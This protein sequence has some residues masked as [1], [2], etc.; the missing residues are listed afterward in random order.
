MLCK[1]VSSSKCSL[2]WSVKRSNRLA[3]Q[4]LQLASRQCINLSMGLFGRRRSR[5]PAESTSKSSNQ[6]ANPVSYSGNEQP[7]TVSADLEPSRLESRKAVSQ[8]WV[9]I[10]SRLAEVTKSCSQ[11]KR[12]SQRL[13]DFKETLERLSSA[14]GIHL[15]LAGTSVAERYDPVERRLQTIEEGL[16][17][18]QAAPLGSPQSRPEATADEIEA[19][20]MNSSRILNLWLERSQ[21]DI[22]EIHR[23]EM[24]L[25]NLNLLDTIHGTIGRILD[26]VRHSEAI[27]GSKV[28]LPREFPPGSDHESLDIDVI[29]NRM[30]RRKQST[31]PAFLGS[32][33]DYR[34]VPK[35]RRCIEVKGP[36]SSIR[37][38]CFEVWMDTLCPYSWRNRLR[39]LH[40][41]FGSNHTS[42]VAIW[43]RSRL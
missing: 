14:L 1:V 11:S 23:D 10:E 18:W 35:S 37:T 12:S 32:A 13:E 20:R 34:N 33:I 8:D 3:N 38:E 6:T 17:Q 4:R 7:G 43:Q 5:V 19:Q 28:S 9:S 36:P 29:P 40:V 41:V 42:K 16:R 2:V 21:E 22:N 26:G 24:H 15:S 30:S 25:D 39:S 31:Q 27:E